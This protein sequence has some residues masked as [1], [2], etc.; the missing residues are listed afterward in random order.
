MPSVAKSKLWFI[1]VTAPWEHLKTKEL[2]IKGWI[3]YDGMMLGYHHGDKAGAPHVHI[4]L[5]LKSELQKQSIDVRIKKLYGVEKGQYTSKVWDGKRECISYLYHDKN[6]EV[7]NELGLSPADIDEIKKL[8]DSI[9]KVVQENK[10]RASHKV[11]DYVIE[12]YEGTDRH[13]IATIILRAVADGLFYDPGDF[14]LEKYIN[15]IELKN[16]KLISDEE[17][18]RSIESRISRLSSFR[19][20]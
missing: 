17:L 16:A 20:F 5:R 14:Q 4:C 10:A 3:D 18:E 13:R 1:R 6:G 15:E 7:Y 9:Q 12:K 2:D 19:R 11:V 8:N